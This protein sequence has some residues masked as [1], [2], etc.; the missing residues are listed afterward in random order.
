MT[1]IYDIYT[2]EECDGL[3]A[4]PANTMGMGNPMLPTAEEPG[5]EPLTAK[6]KTEK[7]QKRKV[8][9]PV[10]EGVLADMENTLKNGDITAQVVDFVD[11]YIDNQ[12]VEYKRMDPDKTRTSYLNAMQLEGKNTIIIDVA[13]DD[14]RQID[15]VVI[16]DAIPGNIKTIKFYNCKH[17][18]WIR[19]FIG[20]ISK[21]DIEVYTDNGKSFGN[22][23]TVFKNTCNDVKFGKL[24]CANFRINGMG[25]TTLTID[26][27]SVVL[28]FE[29]DSLHKLERMYGTLLNSD[30]VS[31]PKKVIETYLSQ[32]GIIPWGCKLTVK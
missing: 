5:T 17:G 31:L 13:K 2:I 26:N 32:A 21:V 12:M 4:T 11:W 28:E 22:I 20:D 3:C 1:S 24:T 8:D 30:N 14:L 7:K 19:S 27:D 6:T 9:K 18:I 25:I 29:A 10:K 16:K 15:V 23:E